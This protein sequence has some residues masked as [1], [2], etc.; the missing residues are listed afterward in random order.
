MIPILERTLQPGEGMK[1]TSKDTPATPSRRLL[2]LSRETL[3]L[4]TDDDLVV[5]AGGR[6]C[7][8]YNFRPD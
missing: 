7:G 2:K 3:R 8:C 5:V 6:S 4:L 1:R